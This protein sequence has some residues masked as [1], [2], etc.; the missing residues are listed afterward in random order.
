MKGK[1]KDGTKS[2]GPKIIWIVEQPPVGLDIH[3]APLLL[4]MLLHFFPRSV[5][6]FLDFMTH[7]SFPLLLAGCSSHLAGL[8][9]WSSLPHVFLV[10]L[11]LA[12][13]I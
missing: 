3:L 9:L 10:V 11:N 5:V 6:R 8:G 13:A 2:C 12:S 1:G 4:D 7:H